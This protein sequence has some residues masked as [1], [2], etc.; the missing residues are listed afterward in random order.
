[1]R[2]AETIA[3]KLTGGALTH[4]REAA[5]SMAWLYQRAI[6]DASWQ[7]Q[8]GNAV[9]AAGSMTREQKVAWARS[10]FETDPFVKRGILTATEFVFA[11][12]IDGPRTMQASDDP[13]TQA[14][15]EALDDFWNDPGNQAAMFAAP[16]QCQRST[17]LLLDGDLF[18][19]LF[20]KPDGTVQ[21]RRFPSLRIERIVV[22]PDDSSRPLYYA[23]KC[24][25]KAW[26]AKDADWRDTGETYWVFYR[27]F[28]NTDPLTDPLADVVTADPDVFMVHVSINATEDCGFGVPEPLASLS[29]LRA[30]KKLAEDQ[31]TISASSAS[32]MNSL[33]TTTTNETA[34]AALKT[35]M[36]SVTG[37]NTPAPPLAGGMNILSDGV[38]LKVTRASTQAGDAW[39][40]SRLMRI[41]AA[42]GMGLG[43]HYMA[44][45]ENANLATSRSMELPI[46]KHLE[47]YQTLWRWVYSTLFEFVL[48]RQG[49]DASD[50]DYDIPF[51][52]LVEPEI[53]EQATAVFEGL[54]RGMLTQ[55]QASQRLMELLHFDDIPA[56]LQELADD[57]AAQDKSEAD[58]LAATMA[59]PPAAGADQD[60]KPD[61]DEAPDETA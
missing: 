2:L 60:D 4:L 59:A 18:L 36:Q 3:D 46:L 49:Y 50:V 48:E 14:A 34:L 52:N 8:S 47:T 39:Q 7:V 56:R 44:D 21:V 24:N 32:L 55:T 13:K 37:S 17:Q 57:E 45:P 22:D 9:T 51:A 41:P 5:N 20:V 12:G 10:C 11:Q 30:A 29:W 15:H 33:T 31:A 27:D 16:V 25:R 54:D 61:A 23:A 35:S 53:G 28:R 6:E 40:N 42:A 1:M 26:N 38:D 43:L 58:E 19:A